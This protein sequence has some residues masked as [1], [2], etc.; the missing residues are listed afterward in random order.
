MVHLHKGKK[1]ASFI[2]TAAGCDYSV[3]HKIMVAD[4]YKQ[5]FSKKNKAGSLKVY[6]HITKLLS[7]NFISNYE[8]YATVTLNQNNEVSL[9]ACLSSF[10]Y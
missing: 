7:E 8:R 3:H 2:Q 6:N 10:Q 4:N 9:W 1:H 5:I